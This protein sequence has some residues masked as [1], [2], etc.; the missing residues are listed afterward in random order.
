MEQETDQ[1][2]EQTNQEPT[3]QSPVAPEE[4]PADHHQAISQSE[5]GKLL[6]SERKKARDQALREVKKKGQPD[7]LQELQNQM[8]ELKTE[9]SFEKAMRKHSLNEDQST[10]LKQMANSVKPDDIDSWISDTI[11][12]L[13][14]TTPPTAPP[15]VSKPAGPSVSDRGSPS[16][17]SNGLAY[18][19]V[20]TSTRDDI[21]RIQAENKGN[22]KAVRDKF[23]EGLKNMR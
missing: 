5:L 3:E 11:G 23:F 16:R 6:A 2:V 20:L 14:L 17:E 15:D 19:N 22:V 1:N 7:Q 12:K 8:F 9:L 4:T 13:G 21:R 18:S 10:V